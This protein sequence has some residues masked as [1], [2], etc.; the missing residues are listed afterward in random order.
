MGQS[1]NDVYPT[2][3]R[4]ALLAAGRT[5]LVDAARALA[6]AFGEKSGD[7]RRAS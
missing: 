2:A 7:V 1:T 4:L 5:P 3:T 6:A